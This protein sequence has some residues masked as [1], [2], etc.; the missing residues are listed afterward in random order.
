M[1][2]D[3]RVNEEFND[4]RTGVDRHMGCAITRLVRHSIADAR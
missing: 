4:G 3:G 2:S 1:L